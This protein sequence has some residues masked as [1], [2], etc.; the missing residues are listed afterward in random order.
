MPAGCACDLAARVW[1]RLLGVVSGFSSQGF[2]L[3]E[4]SNPKAG[5]VNVWSFAMWVG[6][7]LEFLKHAGLEEAEGS[8]NVV[9]RVVFFRLIGMA[10]GDLV[11]CA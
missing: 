4:T 9:R 2:V 7:R 1:P 8:H 3:I 6:N 10:R 11:V 5:V